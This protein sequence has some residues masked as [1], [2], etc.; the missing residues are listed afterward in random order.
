MLVIL[1]ITAA[2]CVSAGDEDS[3]SGQA[4]RSHSDRA[5][6]SRNDRVGDAGLYIDSGAS[7]ARAVRDAGRVSEPSTRGGAE[8]DAEA[9]DDLDAGFPELSA[10]VLRD[11]T[12]TLRCDA[13]PRTTLAGCVASTT[14]V[15]AR[16]T[17]E[18]RQR[19]LAIVMRC[20]EV[21]GC[22]YVSCTLQ[23]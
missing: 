14:S 8:L 9:D 20:G 18:A 11:C 3:W 19:F 16:A 13:N 5:S 15:L 21:R 22:D 1:G 10:P 17:P 7:V 6:S 2:A 12:E 23:P 4:G